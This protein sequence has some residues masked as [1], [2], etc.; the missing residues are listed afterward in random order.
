MWIDIKDGNNT[1]RYDNGKLY[2]QNAET[3]KWNVEAK[4]VSS[5]SYAGQIL[6]SLTSM[7]GGDKNSFGSQFLGLF[8]NDNINTT[9]MDGGSNGTNAGKN[10]TT[11][12]GSTIFTAFKQDVQLETTSGTKQ[13][14]FYVSLFHEL[15][16]SFADQV[17]DNKIL[18][19]TWTTVSTAQDSE[20]KIPKSEVY[21]STIENVLRAE[22]SLTLRLNYSPNTTNTQLIQKVSTVSLINN[23]IYK[24]NPAIQSIFNSIIQ[25]KKSK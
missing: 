6:S 21:A 10:G 15:G 12:D 3:K 4:N 25:S 22:Q 1:Y 24:L 13:S 18:R 2:T 7:T 8:A 17:F 20:A 16:H 19:D 9:I 11:L 5:D 14:P 23:T